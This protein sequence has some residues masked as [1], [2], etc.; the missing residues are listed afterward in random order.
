MAGRLPAMRRRPGW[1]TSGKIRDVA[2]THIGRAIA[3]AGTVPT[4]DASIR[5][6]SGRSVS[7]TSEILGRNQRYLEIRPLARSVGSRL[8]LG[9]GGSAIFG[10]ARITLNVTG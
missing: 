3:T 10:V 6:A 8:R 5:M 2:V 1:L 7:E 9:R 4:G